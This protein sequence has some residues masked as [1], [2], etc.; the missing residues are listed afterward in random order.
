MFSFPQTKTSQQRKT[1]RHCRTPMKSDIVILR[2]VFFTRFPANRDCLLKLYKLVKS[3]RTVC[4]EFYL[5]KRFYIELT[6]YG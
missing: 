6:S 4:R 5:E 1:A 3:A 2:L